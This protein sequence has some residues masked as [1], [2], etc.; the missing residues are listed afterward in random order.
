MVHKLF[1]YWCYTTFICCETIYFSDN[2]CFHKY[3]TFT[4]KLDRYLSIAN[5]HSFKCSS[6]LV[7]KWIVSDNLKTTFHIPYCVKLVQKTRPNIEYLNIMCLW[8]LYFIWF[9]NQSFSAYGR[10]VTSRTRAA[11]EFHTAV[12]CGKRA[13]IV[14]TSR[15]R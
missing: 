11:I 14:P 8:V 4:W 13:L 10:I 3:A 5:K 7:L 2:M 15:D 12:S 6:H 1:I 9:Q